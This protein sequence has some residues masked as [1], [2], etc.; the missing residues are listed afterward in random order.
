MLKKIDKILVLGASGMIGHKVFE[1][2][3]GYKVFDVYGTVTSF[4]SFNKLLPNRFQTK[5]IDGIYANSIET[6]D[7]LLKSIKPDVVINCIGITKQSI[8]I[9]D[10]PK[11]IRT[12]AL[13]PHQLASICKKNNSRLITFTTDCV[14]DGFKG[15]YKDDDLPT[16]HDVYGMTKFL[17]EIRDMENVLTLRTSII[18]HEIKSNL[19]L[20]DWFLSQ[21]NKIKGYRKAI[22]SGFTTLEFSRLLAEKIIPNKDLW[23][24]YQISVNPISKYDLLKLVSG[25]YKKKIDIGID[26]S[27]EIDRSLNSDLL[28]SK[29]GYNPPDWKILIDDLYNDFL[30]SDFYKEKRYKYEKTNKF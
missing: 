17:G 24:L 2:L 25:V 13:F 20:L 14:F 19:G 9:M 28:R 8:Q 7:N 30:K 12:N 23:G 15:H 18:G 29:I 3:S 21:K 27:V 4:R 26:D 5:I 22:F 6:V 16:C 10:L 1:V 11:S